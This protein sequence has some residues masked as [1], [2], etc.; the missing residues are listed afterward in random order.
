VRFISA[1]ADEGMRGAYLVGTAGNSERDQWIDSELINFG[2]GVPS[3][4]GKPVP[5]LITA[6]NSSA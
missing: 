2:R 1:Y 4:G 5:V 3:T 6:A